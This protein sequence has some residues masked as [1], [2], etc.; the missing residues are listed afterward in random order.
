[1]GNRD[2]ESK[3]GVKDAR[4][5]VGA[6]ALALSAGLAFTPLGPVPAAI[7]GATAPALKLSY[8]LLSRAR[9]RREDRGARALEQAAKI[10]DAG[11]DIFEER[12]AHDE[13][14]LELLARVL[15]AAE[16][17]PLE[18]KV[19]A[20]ARVLAEGLG[21]G[22]SAHEGLI[23]AA[24]LADLEAP[25]VAV[26][27]YLAVTP[28]PPEELRH[29]NGVDPRGWEAGQLARAAPQVADLLDGLLAV[30][31]GHG[32]IR[33]QG[34]VT[35]PG[36]I[37]PAQWKA[38]PLGLRCLLLLGEEIPEPAVADAEGADAE[39]PRRSRSPGQWGPS[40]R[41]ASWAYT[42]RRDGR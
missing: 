20:L 4:L 18:R 5:D 8:K 34:G 41:A 11:L 21:D 14:R 17:T 27:H 16:R 40:F 42:T 19:T 6:G 24:A 35:Y 1:M 31:S 32:L 38:T 28:L 36:A 33:D 2:E 26:L 9:A 3:K 15:E 25:H 10:L 13:A 7:A 23:L 37:G 39:G 22:G 29:G 30:L 12:T